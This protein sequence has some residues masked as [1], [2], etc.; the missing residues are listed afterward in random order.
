M[1]SLMS[2]AA[3]GDPRW[4]QLRSAMIAQQTPPGL[5][6]NS[7]VAGLLTLISTDPPKSEGSVDLPVFTLLGATGVLESCRQ[8]PAGS[9]RLQFIGTAEKAGH[10]HQDKGS[11]VLEAFGDSLAID[12]GMV[13]YGHPLSRTLMLAQMHNVLTPT[14]ADDRY[15]EQELIAKHCAL[16]T[17]KGDRCSLDAEIDTTAIWI[18]QPFKKCRRRI[19]SPDPTLFFIEDVVEFAEPRGAVFH[20]HTNWPTTREKGSFLISGQRSRLLVTPIWKPAE[21]TFCEDLFDRDNQAVNHL[22]ITSK[23][24]ESYS[25]ITVLQVLEPDSEK[26]WNIEAD[27]ED[28]GTIV[29]TRAGKRHVFSSDFPHS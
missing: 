29:A 24:R 7:S 14:P 2:L 22:M 8:T 27:G 9:V 23:P 4:E 3:D 17:G 10:V 15:A 21:A 19:H 20:L 6:G 16:P 1:V 5:D 12:R 18:D 28:T 26:R 13:N 11:F 25:L